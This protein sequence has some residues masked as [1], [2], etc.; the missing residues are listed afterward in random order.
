MVAAADW[1]ALGTRVRVVVTDD[2]AL[3]Q[4]RRLLAAEL[5]ELD[6]ACSRFRAD[7]ELRRL[8]G[9]LAGTGAA[10]V[11]ELLADALLVALEAARAT[12]G[13]LDPT[14]GRAI[15]QLGYDRD[16]AD[17]PPADAVS[18][19]HGVPG[20]H[21]VPSLRV[22]PVPAPGWQHVEL[23]HA[24]RT[25]RVPAGVRL[26]LGATAKAFAADR[27]AQQLHARLGTGVLVSLGGDIRVAGEPPDGGWQVRVQ[28]VTGHPGDLADGPFEQ[29][30]LH[31]G[32]LATSSTTARRWV[33]G[34]SVVHHILDPRSGLP[35]DTPWRTVSV[36]AGTCVEANTASTVAVI[37]GAAGRGWLE[38]LGL[39]ARLVDHQGRVTRLGAWPAPA[40]PTEAMAS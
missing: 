14:V 3:E 8:D 33:R 23:D 20:R 6:R 13:D 7:S 30:A 29:V 22:V 9:N 36:F 40:G 21:G 31:G 35:A 26:D 4:A 18:G 38:G 39:P 19:L 2:A 32:A 24:R 17:L 12:G 1:A 27:A 34:G 15:E 25:V 5:A 37:R 11:S 28:D 16:F 10:P